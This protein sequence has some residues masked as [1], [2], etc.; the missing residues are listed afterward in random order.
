MIRNLLVLSVLFTFT[1]A[2]A[3]D[4]TTTLG[5]GVAADVPKGEPQSNPPQDVKVMKKIVITGSY[6][7]RKVDEGSPSPVTIV[8]AGANAATAST[9]SVGGLLQ[10]NAVI[11]S[12]GTNVSFHGQSSANNLVLL[13]GLRIPKPGGG[14]SA[15][16]DFIPSSAVERVEVLKDGA[17]ALYGSEALAGVVNIITKKDYDGSNIAMR[18]T[19]A[20]M[21]NAPESVVTGTYGKTWSNGN[22]LAAFQFRDEQPIDYSE[23]M[24]GMQ[25]VKLQGSDV[26]FPGNVKDNNNNKY[27]HALDCPAGNLSGNAV[28]GSCRYNYYENGLQLQSEQNY[29]NGLI[30]TSWD[31]GDKIKLDATTVYTRR[32]SIDLNTPIISRFE[33]EVGG[34]QYAVSGAQGTAAGWQPFLSG[35][36]NAGDNYTVLY[37]PDEELG[38]RRDINTTNAGAVQL[39]LG[40]QT[41]TFDWDFAAGYSL[42]D[43]NTDTVGGNADKSV[44]YNDLLAGTWNPFKPTGSKAHELDN[45]MI[46]TWSKNFADVVNARGIF[47]GRLVPIGDRS[48]YAAFGV[49]G[50]YQSYR[51]NVDPFSLNNTALTG[52]GSNQAGHRT[53]GSTF[54]ELTENPIHDLQLQLAGRFDNYSDFGSTVNPKIGFGYKVTDDFMFRGSYG[55]GFK[56]PDLRSLFQG[57]LSRPLRFRDEVICEQN[58]NADPNC[59]NLYTVTTIGNKNLDAEKGSHVNFGVQL[60]PKK[61]WEVTVDHWRA[62]GTNALNDVN[63]QSLTEAEA[64]FGDGPLTNIGATISRDPTTHVIQNVLIPVKANSGTYNVNG[65]DL[66][67]KYKNQFNPWGTGAVNFNF[68]FDHSHLLSSGSQPFFFDD[69]TSQRNLNWKNVTSISLQKGKNLVAWRMRTYSGFDFDT[70]KPGIGVGSQSTYTENDLHYEYYGAWN[71]IITAGIRNIFNLEPINTYSRGNPGMILPDG[72]TIL[73]RTFYVGYSQ[74]F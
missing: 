4:N 72:T 48:I 28:N 66:V 59:N 9:Q 25:N 47:S 36:L 7:R 30:A 68:K 73:G 64:Q 1:Q 41:E 51:F 56:A 8:D 35:T 26:S 20:D 38:R 15:N 22:L 31:L 43:T 67:L 58:G 63:L 60:K 24:Y 6:I 32:R 71:G 70:S 65:I 5:P 74:D 33:N 44:M 37:S 21:V 57:K 16:I 14:D 40:R 52:A 3:Q 53:V 13:N 62:W 49:E 11:S 45:A 46:D 55:T 69:Y 17:S 61:N 39:N 2:W 50:Q 34:N 10:D 12:A 42:A 23:T 29:Y 18:Y 54:L 27:F 19:R